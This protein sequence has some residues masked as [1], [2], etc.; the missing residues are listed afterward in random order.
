VTD[1][2]VLAQSFVC[3]LDQHATWR[4][5]GILSYIARPGWP[6]TGERVRCPNLGG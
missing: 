6:P 1:E 4:L 3:R 2:D 5:A